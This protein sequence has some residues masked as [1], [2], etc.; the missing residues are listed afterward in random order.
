MSR[1]L[2]PIPRL[3]LISLITIA[4]VVGLYLVRSL[5]PPFILAVLLAYL[6]NPLVELI[7]RRTR[8]PRLLAVVVIYLTFLIVAGLFLAWLVPTLIV[9]VRQANLDWQNLLKTVADWVSEYHIVQVFGTSVDLLQLYHQFE[10]NLQD[11]L[12]AGASYLASRTA[13]FLFGLASVFGWLFVVLVVVFYLLKDADQVGRYL[14]GLVPA[15]YR[16]DLWQFERELK[17]TMNAYIRGQLLLCVI[18]GTVTTL[19]LSALGIRNA[20]LL[21]IIAGLLEAVPNLGPV[22]ATVPAVIV[23]L[24]QGSAWLPLPNWGV[25]LVVVALYA[26]IQQLE[27]N[28]IVPKVLGDSVNLHPVVVLFG[29]L[30]GAS[31]AGVLGMLL[32]IPTIA[33]L[34]LV[35]RYVAA[36]LLE[37][38]P[39]GER[40]PIVADAP[41]GQDG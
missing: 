32:A 35:A 22:V 4:M 20:L 9:Q 1:G 40:V 15:A 13:G 14:D 2:G 24:F 8:L 17:V 27:N 23:A 10:A 26:I 30:A 5:L 7:L 16:A 28:L 6:L 41:E 18:I 34:R 37:P 12:A 21:G 19:S 33:V 3:W 29:L 11:A 39:A 38:A 25:A 31:I 36:L